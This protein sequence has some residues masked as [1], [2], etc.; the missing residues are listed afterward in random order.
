MHHMCCRRRRYYTAQ[1]R[2]ALQVVATVIPS[3][4]DEL[5]TSRSRLLSFYGYRRT[6]TTKTSSECPQPVLDTSSISTWT[7]RGRYGGVLH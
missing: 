1:S 7:A 3:M 5:R 4:N 2:K 6:H